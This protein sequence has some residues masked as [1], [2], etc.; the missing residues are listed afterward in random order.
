MPG[1]AV[2]VPC[3]R[4]H[5]HLLTGMFARMVRRAKCLSHRQRHEQL[6]REFLL[7][8]GNG[9]AGHHDAFSTFV[10]ALGHLLDDG[11][12]TTKGQTVLVL[13]RDH[14]ASEFD[15]QSTSVLQLA[16]IVEGRRSS[17]SFGGLQLPSQLHSIA[18]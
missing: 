10:L 5:D 14:R 18:L 15:D 12:Q 4:T 16:A 2:R 13:S 17:R 6:L 7:A 9:S 3:A 11:G 1:Y 8:E